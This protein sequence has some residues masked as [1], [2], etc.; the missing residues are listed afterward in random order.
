[1]S[2]TIL[3]RAH[4]VRLP[5][6]RIRSRCSLASSCYDAPMVVVKWALAALSIYLCVVALIYAMQRSLMYFPEKSRTP[7][8]AAGFAEAEEV[9]LNVSDGEHLIA[10]HV[11]PDRNAAVWLYF[12]GIGGAQ[13]H[14]VE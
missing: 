1:M 12:H 7:P 2:G 5:S 11:A 14:R 8:A 13:R 3:C 10:W 6:R 4:C 9:M